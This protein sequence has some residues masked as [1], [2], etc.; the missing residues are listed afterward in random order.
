MCAQC[1][2]PLGATDERLT[3][4]S[5]GNAGKVWHPRCFAC[6]NC[7]RSIVGEFVVVEGP[8]GFRT[9]PWAVCGACVGRGPWPSF[10]PASSFRCFFFSFFFLF[11]LSSLSPSLLSPPFVLFP[12][13][14][15]LCTSCATRTCTKCMLPINAA[16]DPFIE[17]RVNCRKRVV[18]GGLTAAYYLGLTWSPQGL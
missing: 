16:N 3:L 7:A 17:V 15:N 11:L 5:E 18:R 8:F 2:A 6:A 4:Q 14:R 1:F 13:G 12:T 9:M 10:C